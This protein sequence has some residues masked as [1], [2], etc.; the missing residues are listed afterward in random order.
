MKAVTVGAKNKPAVDGE[1]L[2]LTIPKLVR[3]T[4]AS[5]PKPLTYP[6]RQAL[7][8]KEALEAKEAL[9]ASEE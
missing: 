8:A 2:P 5:K 6:Q 7:K 4:G 1:G 9:N 3:Q